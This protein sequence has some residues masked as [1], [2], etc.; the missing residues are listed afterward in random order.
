MGTSG[1]SSQSSQRKVQKKSIRIA[2]I[3]LAIIGYV[4][5]NLGIWLYAKNK[6][7]KPQI[8]TQPGAVNQPPS[9][10]LSPT[11]PPLASKGRYKFTVSAGGKPTLITAG[12]LNPVD[13][14][15]DGSQEFE[16]TTV[17]GAKDV[18][19]V[20]KTDTKEKTQPLIR[21]PQKPNVWRGAWVLD[22]TYFYLYT[23]EVQGTVNG[24]MLTIPIM[25]R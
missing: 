19:I 17:E 4:A 25:F 11:V 8:T 2:I 22:D 23:L 20:L 24:S 21:D 13:P 1:F 9:A 18:S 5:L 16:V 7:A 12:I 6:S 15:M 3:V 10:L 14:P